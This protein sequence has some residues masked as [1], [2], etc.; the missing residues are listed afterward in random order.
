M[1]SRW[2]S[3]I[4]AA[5][6]TLA[7][8][9]LVLLDITDG[10]VRRWWNGH[11]LTTDTVSGLLVLLVTVLVVDQVVSLRQARDRSRAVA[12]QAAIVI[13]QATRTTK[14]VNASF[15][16]TGTHEQASDE[17]RN[18]LVMLLI[19]APVLIEARTSRTFLEDAQRLGGEMA[20]LLSKRR[21]STDPEHLSRDGL[22][23]AVQQLQAA[24]TP[25]LAVLRP[26]EQTVVGD[27]TGA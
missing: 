25:L 17:V 12:A 8:V 4:G 15:D 19:S 2:K 18:Y 26:D 11:A 24:S 7:A 3:G 1:V 16:G 5:A 23:A 22:N 10:A 27:S 13:G 14:A 20:R 6:A 9:V 21:S